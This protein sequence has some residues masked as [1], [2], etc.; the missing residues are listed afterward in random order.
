M[1]RCLPAGHYGA[2]ELRIG[3]VIDCG[4]RLVSRDI[5]LRFA[6]LSGDQ[7]E[8]HLSDE[9]AQTHGFERQVAHGLLVLSLLD[10]MKNNASAQLKARASKRWNWS[11]K[12]PVLAEDTISVILTITKIAQARQPDQQVVTLEISVHNQNCVLV[13]DGW[14]NLLCYA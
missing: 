11:F 8:I 3:D 12:A 1:T 9:A 5:I 10:G 14:N 7:F 2:K 4:A 6:E 13:Q